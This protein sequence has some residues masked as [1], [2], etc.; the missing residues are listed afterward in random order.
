MKKK[1][2]KDLLS[3]DHP[4][5]LTCPGVLELPETTGEDVHEPV[6]AKKVKK[7]LRSAKPSK[8]SARMTSP[9]RQKKTGASVHWV[10]WSLIGLIVVIGII[11]APA[12]FAFVRSGIAAQSVKMSADRLIASMEDRDIDGASDAA[13]S[14]QGNLSTIRT[15]MHDIG[16]WRDVPYLGT[17]IRAIEDASI[18]GIEALDGAGTVLEIVQDIDE[19]FDSSRAVLS[20]AQLSIEDHRSFQDILP[21][22][23]RAILARLHRALPELRS[24]QAKIDIALAAWNRIPQDQ[25]FAPLRSAFAP[26]AEKLPQIKQSVDE[27]V[28]LMEVLV[29]LAGYPEPSRYLVLLQNSDEIRATG[30]FLGT[31]GTLAVDGGDIT[32]FSFQDIY[33]IDNPASGSWNETPPAPMSKYLGISSWYLRDANWSPDFPTSAQTILDFYSREIQ[34]GTGQAPP[35]I[36]GVIAINPPL[37]TELMRIVGPIEIDGIVFEPETYFDLLEYE[38][39]VGFLEKGISRD[40]RKDL[41]TKLGNELFSRL[42]S[43][44]VSQWPDLLDLVTQSFER[45]QMMMYAKDESL[46]SRLDDFGWTGRAKETNG[47]FLW[48][49][50]S[51]LAA[52]KTDGVVDKTATY[53]IDAE[54]PDSVLATIELRYKNNAT[55]YGGGSD[56]INYKYTRYR[57]Y[58]RVYVPEGSELVSSSGAMENDRYLTGGR[59]TPG[60]VDV[61]KELGKTVFGAFWSIEPKTEQMLTFTYRLPKEVSD[62]ILSGNYHLDWLKQSGNDQMGMNLDLSF[63]RSVL[64]A[65]PAEESVEWGDS[66][67]VAESLSTIDRSFDIVLE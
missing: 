21:E 25:L 39:E 66:R 49:I 47:D 62:Q 43:L 31:V 48:V 34:V 28:P 51:N 57:S 14:A 36:D 52:L 1:Q 11:T 10:R 56:Q 15:S 7:R 40:Q 53:M 46:L 41:L 22:E 4:N 16:F 59:F 63:N 61:Y 45:K 65:M 17:Q 24:V 18:A 30:G 20:D 9:S 42:T 32:E 58:T 29:P 38:V 27:A 67:Y 13:L 54:N 33:A 23:K 19:V 60:R 5:F 44:P 55:G 6:P 26:I 2:K 64:R 35:A 8:T 3:Q 37:F 12:F 50:D